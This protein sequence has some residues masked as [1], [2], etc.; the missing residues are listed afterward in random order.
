MEQLTASEI[1]EW[2]AFYRLEPAPDWKDDYRYSQGVATIANLLILANFKKGTE[3]YDETDFLIDWEEG[4][5]LKQKNKEKPQ[6]VSDIK[7]YLLQFESAHNKR[8]GNTSGIKKNKR[9][10][11]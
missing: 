11:K 9:L 5:T 7:D 3:L 8:V 1:A 4:K 6:S 10:K 2:E